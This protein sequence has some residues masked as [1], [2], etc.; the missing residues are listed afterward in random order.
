MITCTEPCLVKIPPR[1]LEQ[2]RLFKSF[3]DISNDMNL[4]PLP[5]FEALSIAKNSAVSIACYLEGYVEVS[6]ELR[7]E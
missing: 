3:M 2:I 4:D 1:I 7:S 5:R 6:Q